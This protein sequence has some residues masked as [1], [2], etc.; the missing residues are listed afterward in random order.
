MKIQVTHKS[1]YG[2]DYLYPACSN[3]RAFCSIA[4]KKTLT[5]D[6]ITNVKKLG[7]EIELIAPNFADLKT[8]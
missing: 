3:A 2:T 8:L 6:I 5:S 4:G 1:H 7:Y